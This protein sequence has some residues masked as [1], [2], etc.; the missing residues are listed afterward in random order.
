MGLSLYE[1]IFLLIVLASNIVQAITGFAGTVLAMPGSIA[2]VGYDVARPILNFIV[3][4]LSI[5]IMIMNWKSINW[6]GLLFMILFVG[7]G[8]GAGYLFSLLEINQ[9]ILLIV[10]GAII[11]ILAVLFMFFH[12]EKV[13]IPIY[14]QIPILLLAGII[15]FLYTSGGPLVV[16]FGSHAFKDKKEFR[17]TLSIMWILLNLI[18][19][20]SNLSHGLFTPHVWILSLI[21]LSS[22]VVAVV[23]G[24]F[25][26]KI[27]HQDLFMKLT[28]ILLFIVGL[29]TIVI[30]TISLVN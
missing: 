18:V 23:V 5:V 17:G 20:I 2:L 12:L 26:V 9:Y 10:Y 24:H 4:P 3:I 19:F 28:Y 11:C 22:V 15:H 27:L 14:I 25:V 29:M 1:I 30:N 21:A 8:F 6:K 13:E 7:L 16:I